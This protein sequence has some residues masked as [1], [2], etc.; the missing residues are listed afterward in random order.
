M[1]ALIY[2][3]KRRK[4]KMGLCLGLERGA[5]LGTEHSACGV[6]WSPESTELD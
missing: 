6:Y 2:G 3:Q 4:N 5:V 1:G